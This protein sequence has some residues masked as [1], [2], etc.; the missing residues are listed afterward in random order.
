[1]DSGAKETIK[2][3]KRL[4]SP[5][6]KQFFNWL[7]IADNVVDLRLARADLPPTGSEDWGH[8]QVLITT[9]DSSTIPSNAPY[10][11]HVSLSQGMQIDD[12]VELLKEVSRIKNF[13]KIERVAEVLEYQPLAL[14][15]AAVYMQTVVSNGSPN[16][17][18]TSYLESFARGEREST[19]EPLSRQN[20]AYSTTMT[21][22][23]KMAVN[24]FAESDEVLRETFLFLSMCASDSLP[25]ESAVDFVKFRTTRQTEELIRAKILTCTFITCLHGEDGK[26]CYLRVHNVVHEVLKRISVSDLEFKDRVHRVH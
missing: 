25:T 23:I 19:E 2:H 12:A 20:S 13:E 16:Y 22:A 10:A 6:M 15:A 9:Q 14:A 21:T 5:K 3:L 24:R 4:I 17:G 11:F 1:M 26:P 8:G 7:I 18:W